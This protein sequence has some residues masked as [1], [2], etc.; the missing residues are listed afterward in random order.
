MDLL[1]P[2]KRK[3]LIFGLIYLPLHMFVMP[4]AVS[5]VFTGLFY[6]LGRTPSEATLTLIYYLIAFLFIVFCMRGFLKSSFSD[7]IDRFALSIQS[8]LLSYMLYI[9]MLYALTYILS[10]LNVQSAANPNNEAVTR[11]ISRHWETM[12]VS[13]VLLAPIVEETLF[14]GVLFGL[15]RKRNR[16]AAYTISFLFFSFYHLWTYTLGG[17]D[18]RFIFYMLQYLP[19]SIALARC[20][21]KSGTIWAP[22]ILH[23]VINSASVFQ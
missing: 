18:I 11:Q 23:M 8:V 21:E 15:I 13:T 17:F 4:L 3:E 1:Y 7:F 20:Y 6:P 5:L 10:L 14:R 9:I 19:G 16:A 12:V 22:V 2:S